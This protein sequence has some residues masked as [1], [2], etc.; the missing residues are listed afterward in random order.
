MSCSRAYHR[1][2]F[3]DGTEERMVVVRFDDDGRY[4]DHHSLRG[5]EPF[6]EWWGGTLDLREIMS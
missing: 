6:V 1:V 3:P 2:I 4:L 5:E